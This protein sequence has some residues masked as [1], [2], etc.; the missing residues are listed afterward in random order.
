MPKPRYMT[1]MISV[2]TSAVFEKVGADLTGPYR[3]SQDGFRF[4]LCAICWFS[5]MVVLVP[6]PDARSLTVAKALVENVM[7]RYGCFRELITDNGAAFKSEFF[8]DLCSLMGV[9]K[10]FSVPRWSQGNAATERVFLTLHDLLSKV[11]KNDQ[12]NWAEMIP[13][14]QF[15]MNSSVHEITGETSFFLNHGRDPL[16]SI[17]AVLDPRTHVS[18]GESDT[19]EY[20]A[21]LVTS[22]REAW[23]LAQE[24]SEKAQQRMKLKYDA[25]TREHGIEPGDRVFL[26]NMKPRLGFSKKLELPW[27]HQFRVVELS[28]PHAMI[29]PIGAPHK[30][31]KKVNLNHLKKCYEITGPVVTAGELP[32]EVTEALAQVT[33]GDEGSDSENEAQEAVPQPVREDRL[34]VISDTTE[35]P[36]RRSM[37]VTRK[38]KRYEPES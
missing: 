8:R 10:K 29:V 26:R 18:L 17:E 28:Y 33:I 9:K 23:A 15:A 7:L 36:L 30:S 35:Q 24:H 27:S 1:P 4:V 32:V 11:I 34:V 37:R 13:Y 20:K 12:S 6:L 22:L 3:L 2:R 16:F 31:P 21:K 38:P 5:K 19:E 25:A 14:L